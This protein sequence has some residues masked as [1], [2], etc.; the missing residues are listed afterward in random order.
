ML[1]RKSD[2]NIK[3]SIYWGLSLGSNLLAILLFALSLLDSNAVGLFIVTL[4]N[5]LFLMAGIFQGLFCR[6]FTKKIQ[7]SLLIIFGVLIVIFCIVFDHMRIVSSFQERTAIVSFFSFI[8]FI[9]QLIELNAAR[10]SINSIQIRVLIF[11]TLL[12]LIISSLR[13]WFSL[14]MP[15]PVQIDYQQ[16]PAILIVFLA[17]Q[18]ALNVLSY[19][20]IAAYWV[21][22]ISIANVVASKE[23]QVISALL[24]EKEH[25]LA[26]KNKLINRL[27][28]TK[29]IA[30]TGA[31]S[32][33]LAHEINQP[34]GAIQINSRILQSLLSKGEL[35]PLSMQV[36]DNII[37]DNKRAYKII[38]TLRNIFYQG[39]NDLKSVN[40]D[41]FIEEM[42]VIFEP[43]TRQNAIQIDYQLNA[44]QPVLLNPSEMQQVLMNLVLNSIDAMASSLVKRIVIQT[45]IVDK[46]LVLTVSDTGPGVKKEL[47]D[48]LFELLESSKD[49]GFGLGLWLSKYIIE[50][51]NGKIYYQ[52][53]A[54]AGAIFVIELPVINPYGALHV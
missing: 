25:L 46:L 32:A 31:L 24:E 21:E 49:K 40:L 36:V 23:N 33:S 8:L 54:D 5:G 47:H 41:S 1:I 29:K 42:A 6:E 15:M 51:Q 4:A 3:P 38:Q 17:L 45:K 35:T 43:I 9:W 22:Q 34:L 7:K 44:D 26:E 28:K 16:V 48:R 37:N 50:R 20:S 39:T 12:E 52:H 13:T 30:E 19:M 2:V 53:Q 18:L 27:I 10:S 14:A 11:A